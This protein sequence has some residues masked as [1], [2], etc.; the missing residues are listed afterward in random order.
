[1]ERVNEQSTAYVTAA[2]RDK[3]GA[4]ATPTAISY[5]ID[6]V[7]TGQEIRDDTAITPA[8]ST[9]EI[10]L[11]P[12]DNAIVSATRPIEVHALTVTA[13]YGD[14]DAVRGVYLFEVANLM[15]VS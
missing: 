12:A 14:A 11:T 2:F 13:T 3:T 1:M 9:V 8:A 15:A 5:R 10:T 7:A 6:D 4:A